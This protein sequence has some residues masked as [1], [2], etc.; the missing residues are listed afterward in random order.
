MLVVTLIVLS[1]VVL[2][3][4]Y[5]L[6]KDAARQEEQKL[7]AVA[8]AEFDKGDAAAQAVVHRF[9]G[10]IKREYSVAYGAALTALDK[11]EKGLRAKL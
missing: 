11:A 8:F 5:F 3:C 4:V 7:V 10:S 1:A 6:G 9:L 2:G